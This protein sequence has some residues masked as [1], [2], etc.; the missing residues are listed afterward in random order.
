VIEGIARR[1]YEASGR[2][3]VLIGWGQAR[4]LWKETKDGVFDECFGGALPGGVYRG[5]LDDIMTKCFAAADD[6]VKHLR[7][8]QGD[9]VDLL[10]SAE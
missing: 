4:E 10:C 8:Y 9:V 6:V 5:S 7:K 3:P 2:W 1:F